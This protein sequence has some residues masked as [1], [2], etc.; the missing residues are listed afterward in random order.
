M[1]QCTELCEVLH[2]IGILWRGTYLLG[3]RLLL[4]FLVIC[5][6]HGVPAVQHGKDRHKYDHSDQD[7]NTPLHF[8][9]LRHL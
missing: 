7:Q 8:T 6:G 2:A 9:K 3:L 1:H 5:K 4:Q